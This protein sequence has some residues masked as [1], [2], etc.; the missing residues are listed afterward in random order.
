M[1]QA[2]AQERVYTLISLHNFQKGLAAAK[3]TF[4][5]P[6]PLLFPHA[7]LTT[8]P[9]QSQPLFTRASQALREHELK[10]SP[11]RTPEDAQLGRAEGSPGEH[12]SRHPICPR[13]PF[14]FP[15]STHGPAKAAESRNRRDTAILGLPSFTRRNEETSLSLS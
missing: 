5:L 1:Q 10:N 2:P 8:E 6:E 7:A 9:G 4:P 11:Y 12:T 15:S 13:H 14:L 3:P